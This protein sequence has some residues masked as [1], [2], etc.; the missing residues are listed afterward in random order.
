MQFR[1][2]TVEKM[3]RAYAGSPEAMNQPDAFPGGHNVGGFPSTLMLDADHDSLRASGEAFARELRT[4][5]VPLEYAILHGSRH[6][7]LD[8]PRTRHFFGATEGIVRWLRRC[9]HL[10]GQTPAGLHGPQG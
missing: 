7:F 6:G 4:A 1:P 10:S 2:D 8:K 5:Q 3:N 9:E